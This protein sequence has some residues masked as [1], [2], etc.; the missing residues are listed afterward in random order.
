MTTTACI[1]RIN[2]TTENNVNLGGQD[3]NEETNKP[4]GGHQGP[5]TPHRLCHGIHLW[6]L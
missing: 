3:I 5:H 2:K 4:L 6:A 1:I